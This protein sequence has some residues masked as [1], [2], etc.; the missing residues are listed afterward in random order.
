[1]SDQKAGLSTGADPV[2]EAAFLA[3]EIQRDYSGLV[4]DPADK[5]TFDLKGKDKDTDDTG[6]RGCT[7]QDTPCCP[8]KP[9]PK[10]QPTPPKKKASWVD[11]P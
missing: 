10:P 6:D 3:G 9:T 11:A 1:M 5:L 8:Q 7:S 2:F 4:L